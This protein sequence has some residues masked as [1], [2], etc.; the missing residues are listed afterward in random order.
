MTRSSTVAVA[1]DAARAWSNHRTIRFGAGLAYYWLFAL[2]PLALVAVTLAGLLFPRAEVIGY[3]VGHLTGAHEPE[4]S[5]QVTTLVAAWVTEATE[6]RL[7]LVGVIVALVTAS[8]ALAATQDSVNLVWE[9]GR[10]RG[11]EA[12][13]RRRFL[14]MLAAAAV[15]SVL[16]V[17][18]LVSAVLS[19]IESLLPDELVIGE[20]LTDVAGIAAPV[21]VTFGL[22]ALLY[23]M[24]PDVEV[25]W[26]AA[27][28]AA[29]L[30]TAGLSIGTRLFWWWF[31]AT[32][33]PSLTSA[34]TGA[35]TIL[36]WMYVIAQVFLG[37]VE[38]CRAITQHRRA[39]VP[40]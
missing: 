5:E 4:L 13:V 34:A 22:V 19:G 21:A 37:G 36:A 30:A 26:P 16:V 20:L 33:S 3:V 32:S 1:V 9:V 38:L 24:L 40:G 31:T 12:A 25:P 39:S 28:V 6:A 35:F 10:H 17:L 18:L 2:V 7:G 27:L 29:A 8:F 23:R 14:S 11:V 15:A